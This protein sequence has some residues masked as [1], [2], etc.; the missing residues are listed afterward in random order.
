MPFQASGVS[1]AGGT[2]SVGIALFAGNSQ[3]HEELLANAD[4]ALVRHEVS[5]R[6]A[7]MVHGLQVSATTRS[8]LRARPVSQWL[9]GSSGCTAFVL[10]MW[11]TASNWSGSRPGSND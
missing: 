6:D 8:G 10:S 4:S 5:G 7:V 11:I 9:V 1:L 3:T 2:T